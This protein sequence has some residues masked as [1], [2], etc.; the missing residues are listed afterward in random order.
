MVNIGIYGNVN[1]G[2]SSLINFLT[3][4]QVAIVSP[5]A[6]TT[7]DVVKRRFE[8]PSFGAVTFFD[9]AGFDDTSELGYL[10][11]K[12]TIETFEVI[13]L[14]I[15]V[16]DGSE[17]EDF[18]MS[19]CDIPYIVVKK[20]N[21][22]DR[23]AIFDKV[24]NTIPRSCHDGAS[25]YGDLLKSGEVVLLVCPIDNGAAE[26]RLILPQVQAIRAALDLGAIA[27][28][29]QVGELE[30]ALVK[31]NPDL[32]VTDSQVFDKVSVLVYQ[33]SS[34][35]GRELPLT[36]FSIILAQLK[37][38]TET[39]TKG[40]DILAALKRGDNILIVE[41]CSHHPSCD[42]IGHVKI[43]HLLNSYVGGE[44]DYT[45]VTGKNPLP[46]DL[47][48]FSMV[49][50]CGGCM[51]NRRQILNR[52]TKFRLAGVPVTNYGLLLRNLLTFKKS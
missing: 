12:K 30:D 6:G 25:F 1:V 24:R 49:V 28:A 9:T 13:D 50:Q 4:Q 23:E 34:T 41:Y 10:R 32:V 17:S 33:Y 29:V 39:Y 19:F 22:G 44:L 47:S 18:W 37:G 38:D 20:G 35:T 26:G 16:S 3:D 45:Y 42:D 43:P 2:K 51:T 7:T 36:S 11:V 15:V 48:Q 31:F 14:A 46:A 40:L 52:I 27:V 5:I 8:L 21:F